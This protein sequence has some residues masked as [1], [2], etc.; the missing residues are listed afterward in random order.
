M[1]GYNPNYLS[2]LFK[3]STGVSLSHFIAQTRIDAAKELLLSSAY[4]VKS[5]AAQV[6]FCDEK[7]FMKMFRLYEQMTPTAYRSVY[8]KIHINTR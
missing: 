1:V 7:H 8:G 4:T 6:G 2:T 5:I 3:R